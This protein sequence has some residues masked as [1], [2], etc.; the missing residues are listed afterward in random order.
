MLSK[1][2]ILEICL[3]IIEWGEGVCGP[4]PVSRHRFSREPDELTEMECALLASII[5]CMNDGW[6]QDPLL[7]LRRGWR[8]FL[9]R[10]VRKMPLKDI[11][12]G[13]AARVCHPRRQ[14]TGR[15]DRINS[16]WSR[17]MWLPR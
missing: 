3:N 1:R 5:A 9:E 2:R 8:E 15:S 6:K 16:A 13:P 11:P 7:N 4:A 12:D 10:I 14:R 17:G